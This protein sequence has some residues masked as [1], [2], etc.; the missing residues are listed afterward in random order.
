MWTE[1]FENVIFKFRLT[2]KLDYSMKYNSESSGWYV[3]F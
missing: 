3:I 2:G 1:K